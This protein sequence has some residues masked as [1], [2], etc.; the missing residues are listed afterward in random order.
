MDK[1]HG[2]EKLGILDLHLEMQEHNEV[3]IELQIRNF[4]YWAER[5]S[6]YIF[7][8][9]TN[10]IKSGGSY[11]Q[12]N[13]FI[14]ISI[15][16]FNFN[17]NGKKL[18]TKYMLRDIAGEDIYTDKLQF[19]VL[20]LGKLKYAAKEE[21]N[22]HLYDW[23]KMFCARSW[24]EYEELAGRNEGIR[25]AVERLRDIAADDVKRREYIRREMAEMN[26]AQ[27]LKDAKDDGKIE[28]ILTLLEDMGRL[29]EDVRERISSEGDPKTL[30]KWLR[31]AAGSDS[32]QDFVNQM[33]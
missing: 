10:Q 33:H 14:S 23:A 13:T 24:E 1:S 3:N 5:S 19:Y 18:L 7:K 15:L 17:H 12:K 32:I 28:S 27:E 26:R 16:G 25:K 31:L 20:E 29:P 2:D 6:Y 21:Q 30:K 22:K 4:K 8:M 9:F 11:E